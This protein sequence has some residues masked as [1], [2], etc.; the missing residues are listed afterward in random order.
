[1]QLRLT[2]ENTFSYVSMIFWTHAFPC[3]FILQCFFFFIISDKMCS[4]GISNCEYLQRQGQK[5]AGTFMVDWVWEQVSWLVKAYGV[6]KWKEKCLGWVTQEEL[7]C[8]GLPAETQHT[9]STFF[10]HCAVSSPYWSGNL[11]HD[12]CG[13]WRNTSTGGKKQTQTLFSVT[14]PVTTWPSKTPTTTPFSLTT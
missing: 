4:Y 13:E 11:S 3:F 9:V 2:K 14:F 7:P 8:L 10:S 1:M 6:L 5:S 12:E